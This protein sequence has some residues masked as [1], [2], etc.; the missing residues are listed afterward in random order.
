[1][2]AAREADCDIRAEGVFEG[3]A[4]STEM[5]EIAVLLARLP[6]PLS[7][8]HRRLQ[9]AK[10][11]WERHQAAYYLWEAMLPLRLLASVAAWWNGPNSRLLR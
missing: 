8:L 9:D 10:N 3:A 1:M 11:V 5:S 4:M 2:P 6:L 7:Q